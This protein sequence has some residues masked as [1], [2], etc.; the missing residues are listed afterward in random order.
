MRSLGRE[1]WYLK[2]S[3][4][5]EILIRNNEAFFPIAYMENFNNLMMFMCYLDNAD[6]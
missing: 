6:L 3:V 5:R 2:A 4:K 1:K